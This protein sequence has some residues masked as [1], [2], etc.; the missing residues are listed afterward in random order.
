VGGEAGAGNPGQGY[1]YDRASSAPYAALIYIK[2]PVGKIC[3]IIQ[4]ASDFA[5]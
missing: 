1:S 5:Q 4:W 3:Q 2:L